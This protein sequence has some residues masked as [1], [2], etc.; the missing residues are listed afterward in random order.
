MCNQRKLFDPKVNTG[1]SLEWFRSYS[2]EPWKAHAI[3]LAR[4]KRISLL[5]R[6]KQIEMEM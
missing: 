3:E 4:S 2:H 6:L 5:G 1:S